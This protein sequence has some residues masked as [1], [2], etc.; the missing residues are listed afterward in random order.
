MT[1][2]KEENNLLKKKFLKMVNP[3]SI[4]TIINGLNQMEFLKHLPSGLTR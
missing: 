3:S 4:S 2:K 1:Q